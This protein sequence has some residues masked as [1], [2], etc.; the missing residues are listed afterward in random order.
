MNEKTDA[1]KQLEEETARIEREQDRDRKALDE[2]D[3]GEV[4]G[5]SEDDDV[6]EDDDDD[7]DDADEGE[8]GIDE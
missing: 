7:D 3:T 5:A 2:A 6:D 1:E 4:D 8:A